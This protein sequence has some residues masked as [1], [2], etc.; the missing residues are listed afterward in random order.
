MKMKKLFILLILLILILLGFNIKSFAADNAPVLTADS[1]ILIDNKTNK[2]LYSKNENDKMYPA[3]TTKILTAILVLENCDLNDV[4]TASYDAVMEVPD[5]YSTAE[6]QIGEQL[7]VE[8][9]LQLLLVHSANDAANVLAEYVGGS[10][11]SFVSMMNTKVNELGLTNSHFTNTYGKHDENHYT[12]ASDL[13]CIMQY[14]IKNDDF[15]RIAG[16]ASCAIPATNKHN[17][18]LYTTTNELLIPNGRYYYSYLT[19]GKTGFTSPAKGCLVSSAYKDDLEFIC[20]V[21]GCDYAN[22]TAR[23]TETKKLYEYGYSNFS[24]KNVVNSNDVVTTIEIPNASSETKNLNLLASESISALV[25][26]SELETQVSP[27]ITLNENIKAPIAEGTVLGTATYTFDGIEYKTDLLA[28]N[29]VK[30][31]KVFLYISYAVGGILILVLTYRIFFRNKKQ[32]I[33]KQF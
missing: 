12:T 22:S 18:R 13:A 14:C 29:D 2:I 4:V 8:Q 21:L 26:N 17:P 16:S 28:A 3:S 23:F 5:G 15:R 9:L 27:D 25:N 30:G 32:R 11:S 31:S 1:A 6:I 24:N 10:I 20:V 33:K 19:A 7:T